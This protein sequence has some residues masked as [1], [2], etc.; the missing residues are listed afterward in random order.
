MPNRAPALGA[1]S[2]RSPR[3]RLAIA[4]LMLATAALILDACGGGRTSSTATTVRAKPTKST[5]T[6]STSS[7]TTKSTEPAAASVL[8]AYRASW[9]AF[10]HA[11]ATSN[12]FDPALPATMVDPLLQ[13]VR[14]N[15]VGD[16]AAGVVTRGVITLHPRIQSIT[17]STAV[18]VDCSFSSSQLVHAKSGE[19]VPPSTPPE[20]DG[21]R[22]TLMLSG[23]TWKVSQQTITE[24]RCPPGY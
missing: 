3:S 1:P 10:E 24:G 13:Q 8:A 7:T 20:N 4:A 22:A 9:G 18:V 5:I 6:S 11:A 12:A 21:D 14:R 15:L 2:R 17:V 16:R 23:S 19:P